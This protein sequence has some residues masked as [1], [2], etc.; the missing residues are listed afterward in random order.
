MSAVWGFL[1]VCS[2]QGPSLYSPQC[3]WGTGFPAWEWTMTEEQ[4]WI[5]H[6]MGLR[7]RVGLMASQSGSAKQKSKASV[8][9]AQVH[10]AK[11]EVC[12]ELPAH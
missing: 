5:E 11:Q 10:S 9:S 8:M 1:T 3:H 2:C 12:Q 4:L 7:L 6:Q